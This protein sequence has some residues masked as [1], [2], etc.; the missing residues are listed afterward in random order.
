MRRLALTMVVVAG[1]TMTLAAASGAEE[2]AQVETRYKW[3]LADLYPSPE[4]FDA[5]R[6][7]LAGKIDGIADYKGHLGDSSAKL[8]EGLEAEMELRQALE[9]LYSYASQLGDEDIRVSQN[10]A[11]RQ[12]MQELAVR[13]ATATSF[14]RPEILE[15]GQ[16]RVEALAAGEPKL[17]PYRPYLDDILR[18]KPHTL[19]PPEER[20]AARAG[21]LA[22][23]GST[24]YGVFTNA[25]LPYPE[26]E[27]SDGQTVKLDAAGYSKYR[28]V[29]NREDRKKVFDAFWGT[30]G[31]FTR[32]LGAT[33][34]SQVRAHVFDKDI[35]GFKSCL[36]AA[37]FN[38]NIPTEVYHQLI[39]DVRDNLPTL[40]RYLRL[41]QRMLGLPDLQYYDV[42]APLV[43]EADVDFTPEQAMDL[44]LQSF[45]PLGPD[46]VAALQKGYAN[47]WV[48]WYPTT[49]KRSG[50]YSTGA[51]G[52]HPYELLNFNGKY[53]DVSTLAHESGHSMH[54]FLA[55]QA[56]P[57]VTHD[58]AIFVAE[59]ASTLNENLLL[60]SMLD[61]TT[62]DATRL[63]LLGSY[64]DN[65]RGTLFRQTQFAEFELAVHEMAERGETLTGENLTKLYLD[66]VR[67]YYGHDKG[68]CTVPEAYGVEWAYI[69]HFYYDFYVY[70]YATSLTASIEIANGILSEAKA[71]AE[72]TARRDAY[73]KMLA[74]GSSRYPIDL[75]RSAGVDMTTAEPFNAAMKEMNAVMDQ[76]EAILARSGR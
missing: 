46:Y 42:Y 33:L 68:V 55:S 56:Q 36:A 13:V 52:V 69:P 16:A 61:R 24:V 57:F 53:A 25:E 27:L 75:L 29:P 54:T 50:A 31:E 47:R 65:L 51:Y 44:T 71:S 17:V 1:G 23:T 58:Y 7:D 60:H 73:L 41:R 45:A 5:A 43:K 2:R 70:Q 34:N 64:L 74:A 14:I 11:R 38:D 30:Y 49:G 21:E 39:A 63:S 6:K 9:R 59:V 22:G 4:A 10:Q 66:L 72:G 35:R 18:W 37:L 8:L 76:M 20:L 12:A 3:N 67:A 28:A 40:H 32:T 48:D 19:S 62:D 15:L 26:V